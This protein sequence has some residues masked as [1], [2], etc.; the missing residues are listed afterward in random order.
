MEALIA[1]E[2][3][4]LQLQHVIFLVAL[5]NLL[6]TMV[7]FACHHDFSPLDCHVLALNPLSGDD[8]VAGEILVP[9]TSVKDVGDCSDI[10]SP[11]TL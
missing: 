4:S 10:L 2:G 6:F 5:V 8:L 9:L 1:V 3:F 11:L 7:N